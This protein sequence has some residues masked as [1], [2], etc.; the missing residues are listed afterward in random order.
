MSGCKL[1]PLFE[2]GES[3]VVVPKDVIGE[4]PE[5]FEETVLGAPRM[6]DKQ[7]RCYHG[8]HAR[9]YGSVYEVHKDRFDPRVHPL[10]HLVFDVSSLRAL[11]FLFVA[12]RLWRRRRR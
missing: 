9:D 2:G 7:F 8:Y 3:K 10:S 12:R 11:I 5:C 4:L 6:S 1:D